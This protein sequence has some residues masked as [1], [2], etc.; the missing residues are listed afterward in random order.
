MTTIKFSWALALIFSIGI[1]FS[2]TSC[3]KDDEES[4]N[5]P[6]IELQ[7]LGADHDNPNNHIAQVGGEMHI[8]ASI[9][10]P[11]KVKSIIVEIHQE[12]GDFKHSQ[13]YT[14]A[15]YVGAINPTFHEHFEIPANAPAGEYHFHLTVIDELG[16]SGT[17][18]ANLK[19]VPPTISNIEVFADKYAPEEGVIYVHTT[20]AITA[21]ISPLEPI[22]SITLELHQEDGDGVLLEH[23][24][25]TENYDKETGKLKYVSP[26][27]PFNSPAGEYHLQIDVT[28]ED[29]ETA[30][31]SRHVEVSAAPF[32]KSGFEVGS[33]HGGSERNDRVAYIGADLHIEGEVFTAVNRLKSIEV[34][35][36]QDVA[37][38]PYTIRK[39]FDEASGYFGAIGGA[40]NDFFHQHIDIPADA[41]EGNYKFHF[42]VTDRADQVL[43]QI[44]NLELKKK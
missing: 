18:E 22:S 42:I 25:I 20:A 31:L 7:E 17:A 6:K 29:G 34:K 13:T 3:S 4:I 21:D 11:G 15:K 40:R 1:L 2:Q 41:P 19:L 30:S 8:E 10:A 44:V 43:D 33:G 12:E 35:I 36:V 38:N 37:V 24:D 26:Q 5:A 23:L 39:M 27:I 16:Q 14:D 32:L 9:N 28:Y